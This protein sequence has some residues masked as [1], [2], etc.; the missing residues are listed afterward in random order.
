MGTPYARWAPESV[1]FKSKIELGLPKDLYNKITTI[2][3]PGLPCII[4]DLVYKFLMIFLRK[5]IY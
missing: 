4:P 3:I 1:F 2:Y 5:V